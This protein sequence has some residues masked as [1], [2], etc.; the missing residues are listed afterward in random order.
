MS[1]SELTLFADYFQ[2]Y[3]QDESADG[4]LS[5]SWTE[6]ATAR[7]LA[8]APGVIG[9][10]TVRNMDVP[11]AIEVLGKEPAS[12]EALWDHVVQCS[13]EV[14]SGKLVVAGCTDYLPEAIRI[15]VQ[16]GTYVARIA[17]GALGSVSNNGLNGDDRYRVQ[18]WIGA[19]CPVAV[20][21]QRVVQ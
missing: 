1:V 2:F 4:N 13:I 10:G 3:L 5:N 21:K 19:S 12:D 17:Y 16:P 14:P 20:I 18:L 6:E 11:V 7:L 15:A 8:V 9:V